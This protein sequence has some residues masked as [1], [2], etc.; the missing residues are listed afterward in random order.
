VQLPRA[1]HAPFLS[2][3]DEFTQLLREFLEAA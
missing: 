2:H 1:G 3:S